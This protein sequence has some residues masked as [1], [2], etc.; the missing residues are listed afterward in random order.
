MAPSTTETFSFNPWPQE[1]ND[2]GSL[3]DVLARVNYE[4]GH[5][6]TIT[7]A[8]LQEE[9]AAE[10]ALELSESED[11]DEDEEE[12]EDKSEHGSGKPATRAD[13]YKAKMDMLANIHAAENEIGT[14]VDFM[15]LLL[16][17]DGPVRA[18]PN[19]SDSLRKA[20]VP[21]GSLGVDIWQR[22]PVDKAR[23]AQDNLLATHVRLNSLQ[24]SAD[25]LLSAAN[26][27]N[28][29]VRKETEY[30]NQILSISE[31]G[32][33]V[34]RIPRQHKL[35]VH[36]GFSESSPEFSRQGVAA[37]HAESDGTVVLD[38]GIGSNPK[39]LRCILR[40]DREV[41]GSSKVRIIPDAEEST[42]E[43]R[44]RYARDSLFD[45]E[46]YHEMI[47]ESRTLASL[48][49]G[50]KG[51]AISFASDSLGIS[52]I[53]VSLEL[54]SL[55]EDHTLYAAASNEDGLAQAIAL[56]ARLLLAQAHRD[57]LKKRSEIPAPLSGEK[58][59]EKPLLPILRPVMAF[60][61]HNAALEQLN[62]Y[63]SIIFK[64][65]SEAN[66]SSSTRSARFELQLEPDMTAEALTTLLV[67]PWTSK[68]TLTLS[69]PDS[70]P[71]SLEFKVQ[72]TLAYRTGPVF[73]LSSSSDATAHRLDSMGELAA[74]ADAKVTSDLAIALGRYLGKGWRCGKNESLLINT[75]DME[76]KQHT[77][78]VNLRSEP[79]LISLISGAENITWKLS[80]ASSEKTFW[81]AARDLSS[82]T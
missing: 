50:M 61:L 75:S 43:A 52:G 66:I 47:R 42:L 56:A 5:F 21:A 73:T 8:S 77:I 19:F 55:I 65:L 57:R 4:R 58:R 39:G 25:S 24:K 20:A 48:G 76:E 69:P 29:N 34:S 27:L 11:D 71:L 2:E 33:N 64:V 78:S 37:L 46:L 74:A 3:K 81:D 28:D 67:Q 26:D 18:Q 79:E 80:G 9:I 41:V 31:H 17:K 15:T 36:F 72:T 54:V 62:K 13:L 32:W 6:R 40:K 16:S 63:L 7:E 1:N 51:S 53:E 68:A 30:W 49:V 60:I 10:G 35:G 45:E 44:I 70:D 38:R 12:E 22:M 23:E 82:K 59:D 14:I